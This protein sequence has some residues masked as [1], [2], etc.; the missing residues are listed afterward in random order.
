MGRVY[1]YRPKPPRPRL[2]MGFYVCAEQC[3]ECLFT[4]QRVV[5]AARAG[6]IIQGCLTGDRFFE[7]HKHSLRVSRGEAARSD[8]RVCCRGFYDKHADRVWPIRYA[9]LLGGIVFVNERGDV[10]EG[11]G[12][13]PQ[14][15]PTRA[16]R[17]RV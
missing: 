3:S 13:G 17:G 16:L 8:G 5:S 15:P 7:C 10:A 9:R 14:P 2:P 6:E 4:E 1:R 12:W 11:E